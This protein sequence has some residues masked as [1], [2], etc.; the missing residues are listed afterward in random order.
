[1]PSVS[2]IASG[3][4][5]LYNPSIAEMRALASYMWSS[6]SDLDVNAIKKIVA[7]PM[8]TILGLSMIP[9]SIPS[10]GSQVVKVGGISTN[11]SMNLAGNQYV[12]VE[13]GSINIKEYW[14]S[15]L[16]Y[17]PYTKI[18]LFLPY[19][20]FVDLN[21]D[22]VQKKTLSVNYHV[23]ILSGGCIAFVMASGD[24]I[25]Q[26][27]GQCSISIPVTSSDWTN[28][29][30]AMGQLVAGGVSL[31]SS[32]GMSAPVTASKIGGAISE[33]GNSV[34]NVIS[35]KPTF[36]KSGNVSGG[37]G[38][39][40]NQKPYLIIERPR[41]CLPRYQNKLAGYPSYVTRRLRDVSGFTQI[42]DIKL[43]NIPCTD[44]ERNEIVS[45]LHEGVLL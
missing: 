23:D 44:S 43:D 14:G 21:T 36:K 45:L 40:G 6:L 15:Y 30:I 9:V 27:S 31:V 35:A 5:T 7:D 33:M 8:D 3:F 2:A 16:D 17:S 12:K 22:L 25:G 37:A 24:V 18:S 26:Y 41:A 42:Q 13:C 10:G 1:M 4:F 39:M 11:V 29:I 28:T 20:G 19:I 34:G 32:G 38:L